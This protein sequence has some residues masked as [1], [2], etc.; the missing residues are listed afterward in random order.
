MTIAQ[1]IEKLRALPDQSAVVLVHNGD[2]M[3]FIAAQDAQPIKVQRTT[4]ARLYAPARGMGE[5]PLPNGVGP[6]VA[7]VFIH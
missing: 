3:D 1:L 2:E 4:E 6:V 7:G 5:T